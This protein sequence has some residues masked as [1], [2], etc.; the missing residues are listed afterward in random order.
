MKKGGIMAS[1]IGVPTGTP[2]L[3][4]SLRKNGQMWKMDRSFSREFLILADHLDESQAS[5]LSC[6]PAIGSVSGGCVCKSVSVSE[7]ETVIH[8][9]TGRD[10]VLVKVV[11][12]FDSDAKL[13]PIELPPSVKFGS[14][15]QEELMETDFTGKRIQTVN[16]ERL[17][18]TRP[19]VIPTI[20]IS[21][22][23]EYPWNPNVNFTHANHLN[24]KTFWGAPPRHALLDPISCEYVQI[25]LTDEMKQW[26]CKCSY[27]VRFRFDPQT[28]EPWKLRP[29]HYGNL[30]RTPKESENTYII[31]ALD[32]E[33]RPR[34][35]NL[36]AQGF[37]LPEDAEKPVF[38]EFDQ[39]GEA[40]FDE[41][42][43]NAYQLGF[44]L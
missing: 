34:Q 23:Q 44:E 2:N 21:R 18:V 39:Y 14:E 25:E 20:E 13:D 28:E 37:E 42:G 40:D 24:S 6:V 9:K 26:F 19:V 38:L 30:V 32:A 35:V 29:H 22:Y 10:T 31:Q 7:N 4:K 27:R 11:C 5:I 1:L 15:T 12:E 36:D 3:K 33:G 43:I 8:P 41:L 16:G 17:E